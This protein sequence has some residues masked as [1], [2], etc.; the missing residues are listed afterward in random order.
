MSVPFVVGP[1]VITN[2]VVGAPVGTFCGCL[3]SNFANG[4]ILGDWIVGTACGF[5]VGTD[6]NNFFGLSLGGDVNTT[7]GIASGD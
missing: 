3:V 1:P 7:I 2:D 5:L 4:F 6:V